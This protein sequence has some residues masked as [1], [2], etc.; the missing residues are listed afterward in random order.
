MVATDAEVHLNFKDVEYL[1]HDALQAQ[2]HFENYFLTKYAKAIRLSSISKISTPSSAFEYFCQNG[3]PSTR[4]F[5]C[6]IEVE[7]KPFVSLYLGIPG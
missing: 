2:Y 6:Q 7:S 4:H 5:G 3:M 1:V